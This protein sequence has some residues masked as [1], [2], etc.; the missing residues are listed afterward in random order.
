[1]Y[2][3]FSLNIIFQPYQSFEPLAPLWG[4]GGGIDICA[5]SLFC[6]KFNS[7][8]L[9]FE[10][11]FWC[12]TYFWQHWALNWMYFGVSGGLPYNV[13]HSG[14][15][16]RHIA[17][18]LTKRPNLV[19]CI[20]LDLYLSK[21]NHAHVIPPVHVFFRLVTPFLSRILVFWASASKSKELFAHWGA[22]IEISLIRENRYI[23]HPW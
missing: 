6:T 11:F 1:M 16:W 23:S 17:V 5:R 9:L 21:S 13:S 10:V 19:N 20:N 14:L 7:K 22:M 15:Q 18:R 4:A 2:F 3:G 8:Q 12:D